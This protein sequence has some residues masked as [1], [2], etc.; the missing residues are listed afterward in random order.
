M[1]VGGCGHGGLG[2]GDEGVGAVKAVGVGGGCLGVGGEGVVEEGG[3]GGEA[4]RCE[5][6]S[7][8]EDGP[9][10]WRGGGPCGVEGWLVW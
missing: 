6:E 10:C 9:D 1:G 7:E 3:E 2:V 8:F 4:C 5:A